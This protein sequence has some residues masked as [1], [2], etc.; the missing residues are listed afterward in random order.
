[1]RS[2]AKAEDEDEDDD[3]EDEEDG[4]QRWRQRRPGVA[5]PRGADILSRKHVE[6]VP[7]HVL[8]LRNMPITGVGSGLLLDRLLEPGPGRFHGTLHGNAR[9]VQVGDNESFLRNLGF[10]S[11]VLVLPGVLVTGGHRLSPVWISNPNGFL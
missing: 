6:A 1:M 3:E 4:G 5:T 10:S 7:E 8:P 11:T 2:A 9:G